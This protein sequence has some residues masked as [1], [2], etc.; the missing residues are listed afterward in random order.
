MF[1]IDKF[2]MFVA[3]FIEVALYKQNNDQ[4]EVNIL[5]YCWNFLTSVYLITCF[6][7]FSSAVLEGLAPEPSVVRLLVSG[8]MLSLL[9]CTLWHCCFPVEARESVVLHVVVLVHVQSSSTLN[10]SGQ[11]FVRQSHTCSNNMERWFYDSAS[12]LVSKPRE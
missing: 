8:P 12:I 6:T 3:T 5:F 11:P 1:E 10:G 9:Y 4:I 7:S 2:S